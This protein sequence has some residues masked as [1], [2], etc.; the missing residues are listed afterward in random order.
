MFML[1][2]NPIIIDL[3]IIQIRWYSLFYI[4]GFIAFYLT[5]TYF[6]RKRI[7]PLTQKD[8]D[9]YI[10]WVVIGIIIG[11]RAGFFLF[12][13]INTLIENPL[14]IIMV[15]HGGMSFHGGLIGFTV[16]TI[17]FSRNRK[18]N[19][20]KLLDIA[21]LVG[22]FS[23]MLG[24]I[25][26]IINGELPGIPYDGS[27]CTIFPIYDNICRHP[28]PF[29]ALISHFILGI[30]LLSL[31]IINR[32]RLNDFIGKGIM[33]VSF[34]IGYGLLRTITDIWKLD[35]SI[36]GIK[37]GQLLSIIMIII[38]ITIIFLIKNKNKKEKRVKKISN[39]INK[40]D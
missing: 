31:V 14:E 3:G 27:W 23:I 11:A 22:A 18:I 12:Y 20:L 39:K 36:L 8:I 37:N 7:I 1:D 29:Y 24:R 17:I 16:A 33:T 35:T 40:S 10:T 34:I 38:G 2:F 21:A 25:G 30:F 9:D 26:N 15:W 4:I 6:S 28:Y 32:K 13:N 19:V 5:L